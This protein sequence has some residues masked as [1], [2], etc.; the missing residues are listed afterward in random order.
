MFKPPDLYIA[1]DLSSELTSPLFKQNVK[2]DLVGRMHL[3]TPQNSPGHNKQMSSFFQNKKVLITGGSSGIGKELAL[4]LASL[5]ANVAIIAR[6]QNKINQTLAEMRQN[7]TLQVQRMA[8]FSVDVTNRNQIHQMKD[9]ILEALDGIDILINNSGLAVPQMLAQADE[10][11][12]DQMMAVNYL[13]CVN[14]TR[15][16]LDALKL[17]GGGQICFVSS[18]LGFMGLTGYSG[19]AA[20]KHAVR[21]FAECLRQEL[22]LEKITIHLFFP[23]TTDTPGLTTENEYKPPMTVMIEGKCQIFS[24]S[25][26]A[27]SLL[28]GIQKRKFVYLIGWKNWLI[29]YL[30]RYCPGFM[31]L[32][33]NY[34]I[35]NF[36]LSTKKFSQTV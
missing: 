14:I 4:T 30:E 29:Y 9:K 23:P 6:D 10:D 11:N 12:I 25:E 1:F 22:L 36:A 2:I 13:G 5:G 33:I 18:M 15:A 34:H 31:R 32:I 20:S 3:T 19:Y 17:N 16:F 24:A 26:V 7:Q 21:G 8:G 28:K 27:W 35:K